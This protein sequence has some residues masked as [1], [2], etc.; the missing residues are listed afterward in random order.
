MSETAVKKRKTDYVL[1]IMCVLLVFVTCGTFLHG[2][3]EKLKKRYVVEIDAAF[4]GS[5][6]GYSGV[7]RES[8]FTE[9]LAEA[10]E[11]ALTKDDNFTV[12]RTH[13]RGAESSVAQRLEKIESD[14]PDIVISVH[15][16]GS[17]DETRSGMHVYAQP[18]KMKDHEASVKLAQALQK[19]FADTSLSPQAGYLYYEMTDRDTERLKFTDISDKTDYKLKTWN[20]LEGTGCPAVVVDQI[21][22][23]NKED[24]RQWANA[25]GYKAA[26]ERYLK[27]LREYFAIDAKGS[28]AQPGSETGKDSTVNEGS[29]IT[30]DNGS[31]EGSGE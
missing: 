14:K 18:A 3:S 30:E 20:I 17:P 31:S 21:Y 7:I 22:I 13:E 19:A 1:I 11:E 8:G 12:L 10:I 26:A 23:S 28:E 16:S 25:D 24:V 5:N 27:A 9:N 15:A 6:T 4:G 2:C 29:E